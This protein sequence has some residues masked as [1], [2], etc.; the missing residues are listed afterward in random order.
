[1]VL[2][3]SM[4]Q[5]VQQ[6]SGKSGPRPNPA[7]RKAL[8]EKVICSVS[9]C[10]LKNP[11]PGKAGQDLMQE[12]VRQVF[13]GADDLLESKSRYKPE[14]SWNMNEDP[15]VPFMH[16]DADR[17][18]TT[19]PSEYWQGR[20]RSEIP[21]Y[22][23]GDGFVRRPDLTI[24]G[25]PCSPPNSDGNLEQ[26]VELKFKDDKRDSEQDRAYEKI[27][28]SDQRY[29]IYRIGDAPGRGEKGCDCSEG[30]RRLPQPIAAPAP[31]R[32]KQG[33]SVSNSAAAIGWS[34]V[35]VLAAAATVVAVL[36]PFDGPAGDVA[37]AAATTAA[38]SRAAQ[39]WRLLG[40]GL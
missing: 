24:V 12:C 16:R 21:G 17:Q 36:S 6:C 15:P 9:C 40:A 37:G 31:A 18:P 10:C 38:A 30:E 11:V 23:R 33:F 20:A 25:D 13:S 35:T 39:A 22:Q 29:S 1:M 4:P 5:L 14:L 27:A 26:I 7:T 34:A 8:D 3:G 19:K 32:K 2:A 28:G